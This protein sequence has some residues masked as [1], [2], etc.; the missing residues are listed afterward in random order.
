MAPALIMFVIAICLGSTYIFAGI[1][2]YLML[3][4][5]IVLIVGNFLKY[6]FPKWGRWIVVFGKILNLALI[7]GI[8][9]HIWISDL[10]FEN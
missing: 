8:F 2:A 1:L 7:F 3:I 4:P 10:E 5:M 9:M 6:K